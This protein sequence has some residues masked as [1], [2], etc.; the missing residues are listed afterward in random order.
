MHIRAL[1]LGALAALACLAFA[2]PV[3]ASTGDALSYDIVAHEL[4]TVDF[5]EVAPMDMLFTES[6]ALIIGFTEVGLSPGVGAP[7][8]QSTAPIAPDSDF[9]GHRYDPGWRLS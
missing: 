2:F 9:A 7:L 5:T 3:A 6:E 8:D 4:Q 1:A